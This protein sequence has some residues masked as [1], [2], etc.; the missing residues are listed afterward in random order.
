MYPAIKLYISPLYKS[1]FQNIHDIN[2]SMLNFW[3]LGKANL[4]DKLDPIVML[5][6]IFKYYP[7]T[8]KSD[9]LGCKNLLLV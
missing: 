9:P 2:F 5:K 3:L 1:S 4:L 8:K 7:Y 6:N